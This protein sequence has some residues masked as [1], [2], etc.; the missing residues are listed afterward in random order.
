MI[1]YERGWT[2]WGD[3]IRYSPAPF[4]RRRLILELA[5]EVPF[6]SVLDVGCG[7]GE[8]LLALSRRRPLRRVIGMDIAA[9]IIDENRSTF[10]NFEFHRMDIGSGWLPTECDLVVCSE[11]IEPWSSGSRR[12]CI[13]GACARG[14]SS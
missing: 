2:Q 5:D 12:W 14:I 4:H 1:D 11:V 6:E 8:L 3:M 9:S 10:P 7:N 13:C